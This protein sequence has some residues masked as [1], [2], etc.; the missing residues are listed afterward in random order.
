MFTLFSI[1]LCEDNP[2]DAAELCAL[3]AQHAPEAAV[4]QFS[5]A[6]AFL[7]SQPA[8]RFGLVFFDVYLG[9]MTG[10]EAARRLREQDKDVNIVFTTTSKDHA[11]DGY[12]VRA[13]HYLIKPVQS[14]DVAEVLAACRL[15]AAPPEAPVPGLT[16]MV[17]GQKQQIALA[18]VQYIEV[19]GKQCLVH[20]SGGVL[21]TRTSMEQLAQHLPAPHFVRCHRAYI[22]NLA[23]VAKLDG[24]FIMENGDI[25][26]VRVKNLPEINRA[27]NRYMAQNLRKEDDHD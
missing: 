20:T 23:H 16:L 17:N 13:L 12:R 18:D 21:E 10:I 14:A 27:W 7:A 26:Y 24:D 8:G 4:T 22:V 9:G 5:G 19:F 3:I 2:Q 6:E 1:A 25:V 15:K 11:L